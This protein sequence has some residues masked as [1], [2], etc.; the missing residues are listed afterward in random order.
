MAM[1]PC[2]GCGELISDKAKKCVHCGYE[3]IPEEKDSYGPRKR[4][5]ESILN[6]L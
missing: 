4:A 5:F 6:Q 1:I 2:P 3:L